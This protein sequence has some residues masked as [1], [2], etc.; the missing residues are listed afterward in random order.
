MDYKQLRLSYPRFTYLDFSYSFTGS[1]LN[2]T[3]H[4]TIPPDFK[5]TH[6]VNFRF[7][8]VPRHTDHLDS[9]VFN[10]GLAEMFSY[11]KTT[12]SPAV[13]V[14]A[15]KL[16]PEQT[17]F[18]HKLFI[19]GMG[20]YYYKNGIDF[21]PPDFLT[22]TSSSSPSPTPVPAAVSLDDHQVLIP[23]GGG[24]DSLVT[25]ELLRPHFTVLP[26]VIN[27]V[28][29]VN[30]LLSVTETP[31]AI[32]ADR[33]FDPQILDLN[34][35]GFL[36]GH[37][38]VSAFYAFAATIAAFVSGGK[39]VAF[40]NEN[41]SNEGNTMYLGQEINHQYSK[42]QE[43]ELDLSAY[44]EHLVPQLSYFSFL[45]P[46]SE[47]QIAKIFVGFPQYFPVFTS[48]NT[49]FKLTPGPSSLPPGSLWCKTCPKC[50]STALL[51]ACFIG[52]PG[53]AAIMGAYPPDL[54]ENRPL[55]DD[56]LGRNPVKPFECVLTRAEA[57]AAWEAV[58]TGQTGKLNSLLATFVSS[59]NLPPQFAALLPPGGIISR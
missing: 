37:V 17:S 15:G 45:R 46:L 58:E 30:H 5:F 52:K 44:L 2:T 48:C 4:F 47:L 56:L 34:R 57:A 20:E 7:P 43:F 31:A 26:F 8:N 10:L 19:K 59:P 3:F 9:L 13:A 28:P 21:T 14:Q 27:P 39:F 53:V 18:W 12:C 40:S 23:I 54:P 33:I 29:A 11:W 42:S 41:S 50:V 55:L 35:R 1:V 16:S 38:P 36:N 24:K 51:L 6:R 25:L 49:N 22:L 32:T